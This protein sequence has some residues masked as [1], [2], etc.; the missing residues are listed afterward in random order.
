MLG[1]RS[2]RYEREK[3]NNYSHQK[4]IILKVCKTEYETVK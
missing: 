3:K 4:R 1:L 2:V